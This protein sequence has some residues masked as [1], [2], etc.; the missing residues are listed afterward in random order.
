MVDTSKIRALKEKSRRTVKPSLLKFILI[1]LVVVILGLLAFIAYNEISNMQFQE[2]IKL[3]NQKKAAIE[4]INQ[5]FAKYPNDP[6]KLI[7]INKIQMANS[8][9]EINKVL[10][11]AKKYIS[12]KDYK[13]ETINQ[14]KSMYG[15]YYP[16]SLSAQELVHK[17]SLAQ[18]TEEIEKLLETVNIEK[19][20]RGIIEKQID[21]VLASGD[22][23]YYVE[24]DGKSM[25]MTRNEILKY[26]NFWTL[27]EL[28][29]L[30]ITPVSQ[31]SKIAIEISAKQCGELPL[32]GDIVSIYNKN[33]SFITYA[34]VDSSYVVVSSISYSESKS[35]SNSVNELGESYTSSSSSSISYSLNNI[36]GILHATVIGKLDYNKIEKIFGEYGKKLNKIEDKT[37]IFDGNV[38][39]FLIMS[40]P[41][42]KVSDVIK[43]NSK[44]IIIAINS[45]NQ[46]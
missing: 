35:T 24:I 9:E 36:P 19:D 18:S 3:E 45:K 44:D 27:P 6:Q 37:Q 34:I 28:K 38:N 40:I 39:Y 5:M 41:N 23:Y 30:K 46:S 14:I 10:E 25:F 8:I 32:K 21:Q 42:D 2:K 26:K 1:I 4:S 29:S 15:E 33:G 20:I 16:L 7:Y 13:I 43:L 22:K 12:F 17:I 11:E 31:L